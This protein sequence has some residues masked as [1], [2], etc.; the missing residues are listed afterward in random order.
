[1]EYKTMRRIEKSLNLAV[2]AAISAVF[3]MAALLPAPAAAQERFRDRE[4]TLL[5]LAPEATTKVVPGIGQ[6]YWQLGVAIDVLDVGVRIIDVVPRSAAA[7]AG[8][9]R[10]DIIVTVNGYQVGRVAGHVYSFEEE[11]Q[12]RADARGRVLLLVHDSRTRRLLNVNAVLDLVTEQVREGWIHGEV[13]IQG[14]AP[15]PTNAELRV[16]LQRRTFAGM[17]TVAQEVY[18]RIGP[19]PIPFDLHFSLD[20][21]HVAERYFLSAEVWAGGRLLYVT[22]APTTLRIDQIPAQVRLFLRRV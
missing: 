10:D 2:C 5:P 3:V 17:E 12:R 20:G 18:R 4:P 22:D 19:S 1:M 13:V 11:L 6:S 8:L 14:R 16:T 7:R 15:V 9:E 21:L